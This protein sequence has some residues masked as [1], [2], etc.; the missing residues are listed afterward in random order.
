[1]KRE[2]ILKKFRASVASGAA[3]IGASAGMGLSAKCE[4]AAGA[5]FITTCSDDYFFIQ[6]RGEAIDILPVCDANGLVEALAP[7]ILSAAKDTPVLGGVFANDTFRNMELHLTKMQKMG[8]SGVFNAPSMEFVDG[9]ARMVHDS[10][11][12]NYDREVDMIAT[13]RELGLLTAAVCCRP[14]D[15]RRMAEAGADIILAKLPIRA[16]AACSRDKR[17]RLDGICQ[18]MQE[19]CSAA[20]LVNNEA[21]VIVHSPLLSEPED[22]VYFLE[23]TTGFCGYH[24]SVTIEGRTATAIEKQIAAF[25][26][27]AY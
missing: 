12:I 11:R 25:K 9:Y 21:L 20:R 24:G 15:A 10:V 13:A 17:Q 18:A 2:E 1:M 6:G 3:L 4:N 7:E 26:A 14:N 19:I 8:F 22:L 16:D 23:N 5:D 27:T